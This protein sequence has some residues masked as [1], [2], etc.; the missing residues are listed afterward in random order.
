MTLLSAPQVSMRRAA[1]VGGLGLLLMAVLAGVANFGVLERMVVESDAA[2]TTSNILNAFSGFRLAIIA[3]FAV[4]VLDVVVAWALWIVFDPVHR[5]MAVLAAW[6]RGLYAAVF[7]VAIS[8]LLGAAIKLG[9][10]ELQPAI[11]PQLQQD[12][13]TEIQRFDNIWSLGLSL[14]GLHLLLIGW[15]AVK[16]GDVPRLIGVFVAIAGAGYLMDSL[17]R[18]MSAAYALEVASLTFVGEVALMVWLLVFAVPRPLL[19]DDHRSA[20]AIQRRAV[21]ATQKVDLEIRECSVLD[22]AADFINQSHDEP[23]V[24]DRAER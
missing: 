22:A 11:D 19:Q 10:Q 18:L 14:F 3:L 17:G 4:A 24:V 12:V 23:L 15:L 1:L 21:V 16:S 13:L 8:Q 7:S 20:S 5:A 6:C 9:N 2:A